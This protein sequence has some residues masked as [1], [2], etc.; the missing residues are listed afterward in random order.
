MSA[1]RVLVLKHGALGDFVLALPA[2]A[3]IRRHHPHARIVLQ[4][5]PPF[6]ELAAAAPY[7]DAVE[8]DGRPRGLR[9]RLALAARVRRAR[10][11]R[12]YDLQNTQRTAMLFWMLQPGAPAWNGVA[13]GASLRVR[14][15]R[16]LEKHVIERFAAQ[17]AL[18]GAPEA[19]ALALPD[20]SWAAA[21]G[22]APERFGLT[23]PYLLIAAAAAPGREVKRWPG[24]R[25]A[26][27]ARQARAR[28]LEP[29]LLGG[30]GEREGLERLAAE[31]PGARNLAGQTNLFD[32]AALGAGA[33]GIV[34]NDTG[35]VFLAA[36]A[37]APAVVFYSSHSMH[38]DVCAPR[39]PG[40]VA[41]L[42]REALGD[43][44][45]S[46]ALAALQALKVFA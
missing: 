34:G 16:R 10:Y 37:G 19:S 17:L 15:R 25:F 38:P 3:A 7:F 27:L 32:L 14:D 30:R 35:P 2:M 28:G 46:D 18:A 26:A 13:P 12:I 1:D 23:R 11:G 41:A 36:A 29:V 44:S 5:T 45:V 6:A 42:R 39:G 9:N 4:T 22:A 43:I 40:G 31:I 21:R 33:A 8:P 24:E 20:V